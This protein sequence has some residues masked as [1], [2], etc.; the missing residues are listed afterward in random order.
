MTDNKSNE[1]VLNS[2]ISDTK[3]VSKTATVSYTK[4][5][6]LNTINVPEFMSNKELIQYLSKIATHYGTLNAMWAKS[7]ELKKQNQEDL[8]RILDAA[9]ALQIYAQT[10]KNSNDP[11]KI[12][13]AL[14]LIRETFTKLWGV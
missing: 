13:L 8:Y 12:D 7:L 10:S 1:I 6:I 2:V 3:M 11:E 14:H 9:I 5:T 4:E